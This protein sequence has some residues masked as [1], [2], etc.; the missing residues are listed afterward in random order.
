MEE[1]NPVLTK[2]SVL[3]KRKTEAE[4]YKDVY[5]QKGQIWD[6]PFIPKKGQIVVFASEDETKGDKLKVGDG[7]RNVMELPYSSS[8]GG[9]G[10]AGEGKESI[11]LQDGIANGDYS[12]SAGTDDKSVIQPIFGNLTDYISVEKPRADGT[13]SIAIG[14]G[15][16]ATNGGMITIGSLNRGG[17]KGYYWRN[18]T[19]NSDGSATIKLSTSRSKDEW[20]TS[21]FDWHYKGESKGLL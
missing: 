6:N 15:T 3:H 18:I 13:G 9:A 12:I 2:G 1:K 4:W 14:G 8:E 11:Q 17:V 5:D 7:T 10:G 16:E 19:F 21:N 20:N